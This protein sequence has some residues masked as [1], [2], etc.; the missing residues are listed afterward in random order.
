M[1]SR[2]GRTRLAVWTAAVVFAAAAGR[3]AALSAPAEFAVLGAGLPVFAWAVRLPGERREP[4]PERVDRRGSLA[5]LGL[6][7]VFLAWE[8]F[9][10][11][12]GS[13]PAHPTLSILL[14]PLLAEPVFRSIGYLVW[15]AA[16]G[17]L[18]KR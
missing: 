6:L 10:L 2:A 7:L 8:L 16:G 13:T 1:G 18:A 17:W 11:S 3:F 9:A 15:L 5:W 4:A 12:R 14:G